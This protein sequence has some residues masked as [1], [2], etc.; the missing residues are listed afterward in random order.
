VQ[1]TEPKLSITPTVQ[2]LKDVILEN[3]EKLRSRLA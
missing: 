2:A 1:H 3:S